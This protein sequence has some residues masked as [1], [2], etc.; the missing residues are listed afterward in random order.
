MTFDSPKW[1]EQRNKL[2]D[3]WMLGNTDAIDFL[4][5]VFNAAELWDD[6][7][8][9]EFSKVR[10]AAGDT[11]LTLLIDLPANKFFHENLNT[12]RTGMLLG[13][14]AWKDS[15][16]LEKRSDSWSQTWAYALRDL[17]MELVPLCAMLVGGYVHMRSISLQ[18]REFFQAE[19]LEEY[20]NGRSA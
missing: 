9:N 18:A 12:L 10:E 14:N 7:Q 16:I 3:E 13:V 2:L 1:R 17:Y 15:V 4:L 20:I 19:T 6:I 5:I 8:D 11:L